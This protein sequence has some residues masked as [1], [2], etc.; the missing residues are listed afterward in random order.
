[1]NKRNLLTRSSAIVLAAL[2]SNA[3]SQDA[4][5]V[6]HHHMGGTNQSLVATT[7]DC[8]VKG[9]ICVDHCLDLLGQGEKDM[10][11]CAKSVSQMLALCGALQSLAIQQSSYVPALSKIV[12]D[13]C[14]AC[15]KECRKHEKKHSQCKDCA[16]ACAACAKDCKAAV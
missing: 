1:V 11:A 16:D 3:L 13:V 9:Q 2:A 8:L 12:F 14:Q 6:H 7:T 5:H 10:A 4:L 15:E